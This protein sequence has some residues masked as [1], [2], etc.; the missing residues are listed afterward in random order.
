MFRPYGPG[1]FELVRPEVRQ[2]REIIADSAGRII[3][4]ELVYARHGTFSRRFVFYFLLIF[5]P[6]QYTKQAEYREYLRGYLRCDYNIV[7]TSGGGVRT[8]AGCVGMVS[9]RS[10]LSAVLRG[11]R[12]EGRWKCGRPRRTAALGGGRIAYGRK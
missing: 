2:E 8:L 9:R 3:P 12:G 4:R 5:Y 1:S 11:G 6:S 7:L 10:G